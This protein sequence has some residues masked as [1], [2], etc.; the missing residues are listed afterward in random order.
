MV[1]A[2]NQV[3]PI[4]P[5]CE[6]TVCEDGSDSCSFV[7]CVCIYSLLLSVLYDSIDLFALCMN[8]I[9]TRVSFVGCFYLDRLMCSDVLCTHEK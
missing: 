9:K 6:S 4:F 1:Q 2:E 7:L 8:V 5:F 3:S